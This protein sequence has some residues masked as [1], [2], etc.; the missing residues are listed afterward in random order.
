MEFKQFIDRKSE[1]ARLKNAL[2]REDAQFIAIYGRRRIGKSALIKQVMRLDDNDIYFLS[3][4]T[5]EVNQRMLFAKTAALKIEDFDKV[6]TENGFSNPMRIVA[7]PTDKRSKEPRLE[8]TDG[9]S[10]AERSKEPCLEMADDLSSAKTGNAA[11]GSN[12]PAAANLL[13]KF[14]LLI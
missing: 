3:D 8:K 2:D 4:T 12:T 11:V 9:L 13:R 5:A 7:Y 1:V 14:L 10:S 6:M